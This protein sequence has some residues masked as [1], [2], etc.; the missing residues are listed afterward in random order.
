[1]E[2]SKAHTGASAFL[3]VRKN[4]PLPDE[5]MGWDGAEAFS[6]LDCLEW[7]GLTVLG[8]EG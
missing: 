8:Q 7:C 4:G 5:W 3:E 1:M 2:K 6:H